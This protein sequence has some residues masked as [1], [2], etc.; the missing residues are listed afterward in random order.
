MGLTP[1]QLQEVAEDGCSIRTIYRDM[2]QNPK[3]S[4]LRRSA[5][6]YADQRH[7]SLAL[8]DLVSIQSVLDDLDSHQLHFPASLTSATNTV[9]I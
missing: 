7:H 2:E 5:C 3:P 4:A 8:N 9:P 6:K 1:S